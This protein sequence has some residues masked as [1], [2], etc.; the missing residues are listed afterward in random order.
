MV[1]RLCLA[2]RPR[3]LAGLIASLD[4]LLR[5]EGLEVIQE[6]E[7]GVSPGRVAGR[8]VASSR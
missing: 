2:E 7:A 5:I 4:P 3:P 6:A 1:S 8:M